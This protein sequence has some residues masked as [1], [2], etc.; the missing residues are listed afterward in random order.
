MKTYKAIPGP[1]LVGVKK[2]QLSAA[3]NLFADMINAEASQGWDYV[4]ME[5]LEVSEKSG[6]SLNPT[7]ER[8]IIYMLIFCK[9]V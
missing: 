3:T 5:T 8:S 6:C 2:G 9:E 1:T 4:G 7:Y